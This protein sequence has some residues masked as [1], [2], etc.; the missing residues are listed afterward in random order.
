MVEGEVVRFPFKPN[1]VNRNKKTKLREVSIL[2]I[3]HNHEINV[4]FKKIRC[5][6]E[7]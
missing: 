5:K 2:R 7:E 1:I 3:V 4:Q 6:L